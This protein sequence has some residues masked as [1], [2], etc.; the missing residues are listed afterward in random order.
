MGIKQQP[1]AKRPPKISLLGTLWGSP[2]S[3]FHSN[4]TCRLSNQASA[5][6][7]ASAG[8]RGHACEVMRV[9]PCV[10]AHIDMRSY[11]YAHVCVCTWAPF[12]F[13]FGVVS[14]YFCHWFSMA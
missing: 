14:T 10:H 3:L 11:A 12:M 6:L 2:P 4:Y 13:M 1:I 7:R 9:R 8:A 5:P